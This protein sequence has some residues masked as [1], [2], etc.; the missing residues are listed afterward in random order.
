[1]R[2][3]KGINEDVKGA[4]MRTQE[5]IFRNARDAFLYFKELL[6]NRFS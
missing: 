4:S 6:P 2:M 5:G 1:M 3:Q